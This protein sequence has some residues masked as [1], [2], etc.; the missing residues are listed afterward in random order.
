MVKP[1]RVTHGWVHVR[2]RILADL[3]YVVAHEGF[4]ELRHVRRSALSPCLSRP[5]AAL[6]AAVAA[7]FALCKIHVALRRKGLVN[8]EE[9]AR[10]CRTGVREHG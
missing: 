7:A 6:A 10:I 3:L 5:A 1:H 2:G 8:A 4:L 9:A